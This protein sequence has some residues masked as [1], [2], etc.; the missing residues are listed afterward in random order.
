MPHVGHQSFDQFHVIGR[1]MP[2]EMHRIEPRLSITLR[3]HLSNHPQQRRHR[4]ILIDI[5]PVNA[6][7]T[8]DQPPMRPLL[9]RGIPQPIRSI[10]SV[11]S[12]PTALLSS[13]SAKVPVPGLL[14]CETVF[15]HQSADTVQRV[16]AKAPRARAANGGARMGRT[17]ISVAPWLGVNAWRYNHRRRFR[18]Q[19]RKALTQ[20][21][22]ATEGTPDDNPP[23]FR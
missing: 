14:E 10:R 3:F 16:C 13:F 18:W 22:R 21:H 23:G 5:R 17:G 7:P 19:A 12:T 20:S 9:R 1:K 4:G 15:Y 2:F 6:L 8:A 11:V